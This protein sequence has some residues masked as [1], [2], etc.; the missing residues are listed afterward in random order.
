MYGPFAVAQ[1]ATSQAPN[2]LAVF[3]TPASGT[4]AEDA[5]VQHYANAGYSLADMVNAWAPPGAGNPNNANYIASVS[6]ATGLSPNSPV[7]QAAAQT[8]AA[9]SQ[10]QCAW[11][12]LLCQQ[13]G[14]SATDVVQ[15]SNAGAPIASAS[16]KP[17]SA[18]F[19]FGR[20]AAILL[21]LLLIFGGL[22][23]LGAAGVTSAL[24]SKHVRTLAR[25][26]GA[27]GML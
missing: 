11:W 23:L 25:A 22:I 13:T 12:D 1:G 2:G 16:S 17:G 14:V 7:A 19:S 26:G 20:I 27:V 8:P 5:L 4:A 18:S 3:N 21:G 9:Q 10:S 15:N 6:Q 24:E